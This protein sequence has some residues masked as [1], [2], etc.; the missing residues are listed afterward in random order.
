[1]WE[2][3]LT[4]RIQSKV[5]FYREP[6]RNCPVLS[7]IT[8]D[9]RTCSCLYNSNFTGEVSPE[10]HQLSVGFWSTTVRNRDFYMC[11]LSVTPK[12]VVV[13]FLEYGDLYPLNIA[14]ESCSCYNPIPRGEILR[15][16]TSFNHY[17]RSLKIWR[18]GFY[19][20]FICFTTKM[21]T[22]YRLFNE[23]PHRI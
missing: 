13:F 16:Q 3:L 2:T 8:T 4:N 19:K 7:T 17:F 21:N 10:W 6:P 14:H 5:I 22:I 23:L 11:H 9:I 18:P 15:K 12:N 1:M 20:R